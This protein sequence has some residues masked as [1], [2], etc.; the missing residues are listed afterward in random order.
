ML[1]RVYGHHKDDD[2]VDDDLGDKPT[3]RQSTGRQTNRATAIWATTSGR[4][5]DTSQVIWGCSSLEQ[6]LTDLHNYFTAGVT[7]EFT[8]KNNYNVKIAHRIYSNRPVVCF[9]HDRR[10]SISITTL[11]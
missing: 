7:T 11:K 5:G 2:N 9:I 1:Q 3:G 4:L 8:T 6:I 10:I